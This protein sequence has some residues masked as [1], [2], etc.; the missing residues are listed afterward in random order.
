MLQI[1]YLFEPRSIAVIGASH[2]PTK[3]GHSIV[4]N[5]LLN[6]YPGKVYPINPKGGEILGLK[7]Y[8]SLEEIDGEIDLATIAIP[9][10]FVFEAV[11]ICASKGVKFLSIITSGFSEI[12]NLEEERKIVEY[13]NKHGMR[14]L[15]PNIFGLYSVKASLNATFG[16]KHIKPGNV[17]I[18]TQSG[19][20]GVAMIGKTET[21]G[22]GISAIISVGNKSD[23]EEADLIEYLVEDNQTKIILLYIE[24]IRQGERLVSVLKDATR[25]K[26][27]IVIKSGRSKRGAM[28]AASHTGS[29]A[30]ADEV[31]SDIME[32]CGVLRALSVQEALNWVKFLS[33]APLPCGENT[34]IISNAGG[35]AV[36]ATDAAELYGVTLYD[37]LEILKQVFSP[38]T[39]EFGSTKNPIDI[40]GQ[41]TTAH[42]E[43]AIET[44]LEN[45]HIHSIICLGCETALF[46]ADQLVMIGK[47]QFV[48]RKIEKPLVLSFFGGVEIEKSQSILKSLGIPIFSDVYEAVSCMG[49][50][51]KTYRNI[52]YR[53]EIVDLDEPKIDVSTIQKIVQ[54]VRADN[55]QFLLV[56]EAARVMDAAGILM[57]KSY[58]AKNILEAVKY[59]EQ[60]G[61]PVVMKIVSKDIIHKSD[62][63]GVA[64][65]LENNEEVINAYEAIMTSC[66]QYNPNAEIQG[67]E[68]VSMISV[69]DAI[70][71]IIGARK[72]RSFGPVVMFGLG[73]IYVEVLKDVSFRAVPL[74]HADAVG[75]IKQIRSY[76]LLL[77]V[78][79]EERKDI[80]SCIDVILR[81]SKIIESCR[82]ISDIEINPLVVYE[83]N[84]GVTAVDVRILLT[85]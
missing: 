14:V 23:L 36:L 42:Y 61:Y 1:K 85:P 46:D 66:R 5:I 53:E 84:K 17:A 73:G 50:L 51:Y 64:L 65:D 45:E 22:I 71:C 52:S 63:G 37:D 80:E 32:Q 57:P 43:L 58:I 10:K 70:E 9:A 33:V 27:V 44:A 8:K 41:A 81:L 72:D 68:I 24:G 38:V 18:V 83:Q 11:K 7:T 12:G 77:G 56:H 20:L 55:R 48:D 15:G 40:T 21:E 3:I 26:P 47:K 6:K 49:A 67:V 16:A 2:N 78:R 34:V 60:V 39:P 29:L 13:A 4:S 82:D 69:T 76:P 35:V 59:S 19:A 54:E 79:G 28:A 62:A 74:T 75:M 25:R 31:F 30:G